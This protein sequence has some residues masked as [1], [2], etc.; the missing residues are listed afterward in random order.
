MKNP[1]DKLLKKSLKNCFLFYKEKI[2]D[3]DDSKFWVKDASI[4]CY[5]LKNDPKIAGGRI[6]VEETLEGFREVFVA[7][8]IYFAGLINDEMWI[9]SNKYAKIQKIKVPF[10]TFKKKV[11]RSLLVSYAK[12]FYNNDIDF[13]RFYSVV[14]KY[15]DMMFWKYDHKYGVPIL[16]NLHGL[17][18]LENRKI[19]FPPLLKEEIDYHGDDGF[20][21]HIDG[22][23]IYIR[24]AEN[25]E[26]LFDSIFNH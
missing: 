3:S 24:N 25:I 23:K 14:K 17:M 11:I 18:N 16:N 21:L 13:L 19:V 4:Q 5:V 1:P 2:S 22:K 8:T 26:S 6:W 12:D 15:D 10:K 20:T 9:F 7:S